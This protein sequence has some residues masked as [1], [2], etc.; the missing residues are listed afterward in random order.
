MPHTLPSTD[1]PRAPW[2]MRL[3][4]V[5]VGLGLWFLTQSL[6]ATR[7]DT[8]VIVDEV[9]KWTAPIHGWLSEH[10]AA[11]NALLIVSSLGIDLLGVFLLVWSIFGPS[12]RPFLGLL[13]LFAL[14]QLCQATCALPTPPGMLWFQPT[15]G[16][17]AVP[18]LLVTYGT[19]NDFFFSGHTAL[20]VY[21]CVELARL[22][23]KPLIALALALAL[24]EMAT[25][26]VLRAHWTMD[27]Y[28]GIV[29][30]LLAAYL[31]AWL[32]PACDRRL[33]SLCRRT[34]A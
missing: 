18:S 8:A 24:F 26:I 19:S 25:V 11:A 29:T 7:G 16:N 30:A 10:R 6:L 9:L 5:V 14:R 2:W 23:R 4:L 33:A 31:A 28:G 15:L 17:W 34:S 32:A 21:G 20:A 12:I 1:T 27:L 13:M 3:A 22:G